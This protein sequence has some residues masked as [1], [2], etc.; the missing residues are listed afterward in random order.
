[1]HSFRLASELPCRWQRKCRPTSFPHRLLNCSEDRSCSPPPREGSVVSAPLLRPIE[2]NCKLTPRYHNPAAVQVAHEL[3]KSS[4]GMSRLYQQTCAEL[5]M[6][7][8]GANFSRCLLSID[9]AYLLS[10]GA[11]DTGW[12]PVWVGMG[13]IGTSISEFSCS[14]QR[15]RKHFDV[16]LSGAIVLYISGAVPADP[17]PA[18]QIRAIR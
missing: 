8:G 16:N 7:S 5:Q 1:M 6:F 9:I 15:Q 18:H 4:F 11:C 14:S 2:I 13:V 17:W 10:S 12:V 3:Q